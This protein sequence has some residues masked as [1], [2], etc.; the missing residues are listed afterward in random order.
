MGEERLC[1]LRFEHLVCT[2]TSAYTNGNNTK[3]HHAVYERKFYQRTLLGD[4]TLQRDDYDEAMS[5]VFTFIWEVNCSRPVRSCKTHENLST[6]FSLSHHHYHHTQKK[7]WEHQRGSMARGGEGKSSCFFF[8]I[9]EGRRRR[10]SSR[11][12]LTRFEVSP[13]WNGIF[14]GR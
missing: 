14:P 10:F 6:Y 7:A 3:R 4:L 13:A 5:N 11:R 8:I 12:P 1:S 2:H 9:N